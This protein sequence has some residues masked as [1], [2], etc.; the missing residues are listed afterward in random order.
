MMRKLMILGSALLA[1]SLTAC[2]P[3]PA[4]SNTDTDK[5]TGAGTGTTT[6]NGITL[7]GG[8]TTATAVS[9]TNTKA[10][11]IAF[12]NCSKEK[13]NLTEQQKTL[14]EEQ[15]KIIASIPDIVW[16]AG[17]AQYE[18]IVQANFS[19]ALAACSTAK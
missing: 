18:A 5:E 17:A 10:A 15:I 3:N 2:G 7:G 14:V 13:G 16:S 12:L 9:V 1:L 19:A 4:G 6:G 8:T 11:Y